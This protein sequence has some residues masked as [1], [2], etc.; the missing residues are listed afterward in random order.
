MPGECLE[1]SYYR[2]WP[3]CVPAEPWGSLVRSFLS[4]VKDLD[5]LHS[6]RGWVSPAK[7]VLVDDDSSRLATS[8][9]SPLAG[10]F[11]FL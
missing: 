6:E 4:L 10:A 3:A 11:T 7:A 5:V 1:A 9:S 2:L 8:V